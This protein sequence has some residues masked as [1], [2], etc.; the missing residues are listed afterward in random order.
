[1]Y[2]GYVHTL[3]LLRTVSFTVAQRPVFSNIAVGN[4]QLSVGKL[5]Q[6]PAVRTLLTHDAAEA[7][8][9]LYRRGADRDTESSHLSRCCCCYLL[10][11]L[12]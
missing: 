9:A 4:S 11:T 2:V 1:M 5:L 12:S 3:L 7:N 6:L 10:I 8:D